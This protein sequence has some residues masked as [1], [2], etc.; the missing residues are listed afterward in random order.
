MEMG[1][2]SLC[3]VFIDGTKLEANA[4]RYSFVWK[5]STQKNE[6]KMQEKMKVELP[7]LAAEFG[8]RFHVGE[9]ILVKDLK[10]LLK[11][12]YRLKGD[13]EFVYGSGRRKHPCKGS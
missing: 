8:V 6:A 1:E 13:L 9:K 12:L 7:K 11:R 2:L 10:K 4:N 5:K 3:S